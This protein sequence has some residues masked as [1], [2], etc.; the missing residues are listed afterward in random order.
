ML[1]ST[2]FAHLIFKMEQHHRN[3]IKN[4]LSDLITVTNCLNDIVEQ[5]FKINVIN[6]WMRLYIMVNNFHLHISSLA[7]Q[8]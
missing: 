4:N 8:L 3:I 7:L 2:L 6:N 5:L 1:K